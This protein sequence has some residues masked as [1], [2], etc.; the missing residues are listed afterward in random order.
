VIDLSIVVVTRNTRELVLDCLARI[1]H[2]DPA[3]ARI[4]YHRSL[5][6]FF[7]KHRGSG[8]MAIVFVLRIAKSLFCLVSQ[9]PRAPLAERQRARQV[10]QRDASLWRLPGCPASVG[11]A[12]LERAEARR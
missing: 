7:R 4:E 5:Y 1:E 9:A 12:Q 2:K 10:S 6:R 8:H 3:L 11:L